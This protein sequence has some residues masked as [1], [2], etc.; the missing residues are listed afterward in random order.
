MQALPLSLQDSGDRQGQSSFLLFCISK[1]PFSVNLKGQKRKER[2]SEL[3]W[4]NHCPLTRRGMLSGLHNSPGSNSG[5]A[6]NLWQKAVLRSRE[7]DPIPW[8]GGETIAELVRSPSND[9]QAYDILRTMDFQTRRQG[10]LGSRK[11][12][13]LPPT[14]N[15]PWV[16]EHLPRRGYILGVEVR[17]QYPKT[18]N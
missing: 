14:S 8:W 16:T 5:F 2:A 15:H 13:S 9:P 3:C 4:G 18:Q 7:S 12:S 10:R 6:P 1:T 17:E 11:R